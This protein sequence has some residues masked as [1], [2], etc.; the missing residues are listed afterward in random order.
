MLGKL[1]TWLRI[2]G[3]DTVYVGDLNIMNRRKEDTFL[4]TSF[5]D[6]ILLTRDRE[7]YERCISSNREV[8]FI[9]SNTIAEQIKEL[10]EKGFEFRIVMDRC[11]VCNNLLRRP[12]EEEI[13]DVLRKEG[14]PEDFKTRYEFW[15]CENCVKL[16]WM[17]SHWRNMVKFLKNIEER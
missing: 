16:Y 15:Y 13:L 9:N 7:L 4:V 6:R 5:K 12:S 11:S 2:S 17:G 10:S 1:T 14:L 8:I 3:Y